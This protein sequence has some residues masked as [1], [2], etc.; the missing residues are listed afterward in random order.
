MTSCGGDLTYEG[1]AN[2]EIT[3]LQK[4]NASKTAGILNITLVSYTLSNEDKNMD[5]YI[6]DLDQ[7]A[8]L[9]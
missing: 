9:N 8:G 5:V 6:L 1:E 4:I 3:S 2:N 7:G